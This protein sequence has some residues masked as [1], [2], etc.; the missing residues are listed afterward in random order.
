MR[1]KIAELREKA[2]TR[3]EDYYETC[4]SFGKVNGEYLEITPDK[5]RMLLQK[6]SP[7]TTAV[8]GSA[9]CGSMPSI[10]TQ[11]GN[12]A[13]A[14][15]RVVSASF[16]GNQVKASAEVVEQRKEI[17]NSCEFLNNDKCSKCGCRYKLKIQLATEKCPVSK[18]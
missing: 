14:A 17:C 15:T 3:P 16:T 5:Y 4:I 2:K 6:Y 18:W 9:C 10:F 8:T 13:Q 11:I 12:A 1:L 7:Q